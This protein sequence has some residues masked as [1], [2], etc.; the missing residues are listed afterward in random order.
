MNLVASGM[1]VKGRR[2][3]HTDLNEDAILIDEYRG[4]FVVADGASGFPDGAAAAN[5]VVATFRAMDEQ[6]PSMECL[7]AAFV[8]AE[9]AIRLRCF[10]KSLP[11]LPRVIVAVV[12]LAEVENGW[13]EGF[14]AHAGDASVFVLDHMR[15]VIQFATIPHTER[16]GDGRPEVPIRFIGGCGTP[17]EIVPLRVRA[18][19]TVLVVSDGVTKT[20]FGSDILSHTMHQKTPQALT[21]SL[22]RN[23][24]IREETDDISVVAVRTLRF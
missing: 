19:S 12:W 1:S 4:L 8:A 17:P 14:V 23:A 10:E 16:D 11:R 24:L 21:G 9:D 18:D 13:H 7:A 3:L 2:R 5:L 15:N 6:S 22:V 20:L